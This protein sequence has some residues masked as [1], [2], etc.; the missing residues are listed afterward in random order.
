MTTDYSLI[1]PFWKLRPD[2]HGVDFDGIETIKSKLETVYASIY[3]NSDLS[4]SEPLGQEI[5]VLTQIAAH[6][7]DEQVKMVNYFFGGGTGQYLDKWAFINFYQ[8]RNQAQK[9]SVLIKITGV[10]G[11]VVPVGYKISDGKLNYELT[12]ESTIGDD[13]TVQAVFYTADFTKGISLANT[14]TK[15]ITPLIGIDS[16]I[17][18]ADSSPGV[19]V[20]N[21]SSF[22]KRCITY[23]PAFVNK[24]F[25]S[26]NAVLSQLP[27]VIKIASYE[28]TQSKE[29]T[30]RGS[31]FPAHSVNFV[32]YGG[33]D[34]VIANAI[35][36]LKDQGVATSG[37]VKIKLSI[38][39]VE[40]EYQFYRPTTVPMKIEAKIKKD[41]DTPVNY[42]A[43]LK[44]LAT[45][46]VESIPIGGTLYQPHLSSYLS[47][48]DNIYIDTVKLSKK[49]QAVGFNKI[50]LNFIEMATI[51][52]NDITIST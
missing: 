41:S 40:Y 18:E 31:K 48:Y 9:G 19:D 49:T 21:D 4:P 15:L 26:M 17:N 35:R 42:V 5:T 8:K 24:N 32:F 37:N 20:E 45:Q 3:P 16:V 47:Q 46:Y 52:D 7:V 11:T 39:N 27:G 28:N 50:E 29:I 6:C 14:I 36:E 44:S 23:G 34:N 1:E 51:T 25:Q 43:L 10:P 38:H 33:D 22:Y 30:Y 2:L 13:G 12:E